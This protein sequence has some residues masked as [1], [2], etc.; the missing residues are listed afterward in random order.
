M[1][2]TSGMGLLD[3]PFA[4]W[5]VESVRN[6]SWRPRRPL[7]YLSQTGKELLDCRAN[8]G[9][10][11]FLDAVLAADRRF[12]IERAVKGCGGYCLQTARRLQFL[13]AGLTEAWRAQAERYLKID[14]LESRT[15]MER[16]LVLDLW[17]YSRIFQKVL[18]WE[19]PW[20]AAKVDV[21]AL[22]PFGLLFVSHYWPDFLPSL[23]EAKLWQRVLL[24]PE[25]AMDFLA[26][27][28]W[29]LTLWDVIM[30]MNHS[31][32]FKTARGMLSSHGGADL[33]RMPLLRT[34]IDPQ[35]LSCVARFEGLPTPHCR[36]PPPWR[37][38]S[39]GLQLA[40][41][42]GHVSLTADIASVL[43]KAVPESNVTVLCRDEV[44]LKSVSD[45][46][47]ETQ[48]MLSCSKMCSLTAGFCNSPRVGF[49]WQ[50]DRKEWVRNRADVLVCFDYEICV[51]MGARHQKPL[52]IYDGMQ[53][54]SDTGYPDPEWLTL[55]Y[56]RELVEHDVYVR[57]RLQ[58]QA[59]KP[60]EVFS[61]EAPNLPAESR[62][63]RNL[64]TLLVTNDPWNAESI[65]FRTGLRVP[66]A[67]VV[68]YYLSCRYNADSLRSEH[69]FVLNCR[70]RCAACQGFWSFVSVVT[71][72][73]YPLAFYRTEDYVNYCS[74][75]KK[76]RAMVMVPHG[77][78][79]QMMCFEA[80]NMAMPVLLPD[81]RLMSRQPFLWW[82]ERM[83]HACDQECLQKFRDPPK[84]AA[85]ERPHPFPFLVT[86]MP[87]GPDRV[88]GMLYWMRLLDYFHWDWALHF[89]SVPHL[90]EMLLKADLLQEASRRQRR[91]ML[92][93]KRRARR[94]WRDGVVKLV[95]K[96]EIGRAHV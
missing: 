29:P 31:S 8:Q 77:N 78:V 75:A 65:F 66:S 33:V 47:T 22:C 46:R 82:S 88:M 55:P 4:A 58:R 73:N 79:M 11:Y 10:S 26:S 21:G 84:P 52:L 68:S 89:E 85:F 25:Y 57:E 16:G 62:L 60:Y 2:A 51:E 7:Q 87:E 14:T 44:T 90:L 94:F 86:T 67:R 81:L 36:T 76:F 71:P 38:E 92:R 43:M 18:C 35:G 41:T 28:S 9:W 74:L 70:G 61:Q 50:P 72:E 42:M 32:N 17:T 20:E 30:E 96:L 59:L 56:L 45:A 15:D 49:H 80:T 19:L 1:A 69:V 54:G 40:V 23:G 34:S 12:G 5:N 95:E 93:E 3:L 39:E 53:Y 37:L 27:S 6:F 48:H 83:T 13:A 63:P 24:G 91:F 64:R